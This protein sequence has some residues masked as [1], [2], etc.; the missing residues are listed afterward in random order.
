MLYFY[1]LFQVTR[2]DLPSPQEDTPPPYTPG[3]YIYRQPDPTPDPA[4]ISGWSHEPL[5]NFDPDEALPARSS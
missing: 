5:L 3:P 1:R 2:R 4:Q